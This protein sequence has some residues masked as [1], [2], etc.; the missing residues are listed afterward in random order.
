[1]NFPALKI[2]YEQ[3]E[4]LLGPQELQGYGQRT[5]AFFLWLTYALGI[6]LWEGRGKKVEGLASHEVSI[7]DSRQSKS[8]AHISST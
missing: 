6:R 1:M 7:D 8:L 4:V 5:A 3:R 2:W